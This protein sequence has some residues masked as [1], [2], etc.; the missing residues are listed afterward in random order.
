[1][2]LT[3]LLWLAIRLLGALPL[4][5]RIQIGRKLA[6]LFSFF[7]ARD[8]RIARLQLSLFLPGRPVKLSSVYASLGQNFMETVNLAPIL[9]NADAHIDCPD[10]TIAEEVL[11]CGKSVVAL[12][13]HLG[14]WDL[15]AAYVAARGVR[16]AT[17]GREAQ[18]SA[19]HQALVK[20]RSRYGIRT[21]WRSDPN[22]LRTLVAELRGGGVIAALIDQDTQV[23]SLFVPFLGRPARTPSSL[24]ALA[25]KYEAAIV[26][27]FIFRDRPQHYT[28]R[29][30]R[31]D[32]SL[33]VSEIL[34]EYSAQL[35]ALVHSFP[36]QWVWVHKR[37][38]TLEN[39]HRM[40]SA[41][42]LAFLEKALD[43]A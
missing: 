26:S 14:N 18:F 16:L 10:W 8:S 32:S 15:L 36:E 24:V 11:A 40:S 42:Y 23:D 17:I 28:I 37:W 3:H 38:R 21:I 2:F 41:E 43:T 34:S 7:P 5:L 25:R 30:R 12:T 31:L 33:T 39:G 13:A 29:I 35:S 4:S 22:A 27:T 1:M 20:L 9:H 6:A 19:L